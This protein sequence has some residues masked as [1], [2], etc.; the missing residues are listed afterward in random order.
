VDGEAGV[1]NAL[2]MLKNELEVAM[3]LSGCASLKEITR[4]HVTTE[5]D[6][7]RRSML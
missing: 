1:R 3:A 2:Q 4:G 5:G 6:R 7:I